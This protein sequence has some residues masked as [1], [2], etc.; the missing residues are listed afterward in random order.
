[1]NAQKNN[2]IGAMNESLPSVVPFLSKSL[3]SRARCVAGLASDDHGYVP[4]LRG[5]D[6]ILLTVDG[7]LSWK[8]DQDRISE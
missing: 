6:A 5:V 7:F 2:I 1:M 3:N 8:T 4:R